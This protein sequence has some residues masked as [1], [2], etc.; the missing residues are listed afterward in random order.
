MCIYQIPYALKANF[1]I[2]LFKNYC[3]LY[4]YVYC[5]AIIYN[6]QILYA[7]KVVKSTTRKM[8]KGEQEGVDYFFL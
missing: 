6:C 2:I 5:K 4:K 8:D 1:Y 3:I 7:L